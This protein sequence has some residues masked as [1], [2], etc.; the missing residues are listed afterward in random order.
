[1]LKE[2]RLNS[3]TE[4]GLRTQPTSWVPFFN[5]LVKVKII[6]KVEGGHENMFY[7]MDKSSFSMKNRSRKVVAMTG[8]KNVWTKNTETPFHL[9][10]V[11]EVCADGSS[12]T[13][14]FILPGKLVNRGILNEIPQ[15]KSSIIFSKKGLMNED[16]F[17]QWILHLSDTIID[18]EFSLSI[19]IVTFPPNFTIL[20]QPLDVSFFRYFKRVMQEKYRK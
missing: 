8:S 3:S 5:T 18:L 13:P 2:K 7:N 17:I 9:T 6:L 12:Q 1:M 14:L 10:I 11:G 15:V 4:F 16:I 20:I 19:M